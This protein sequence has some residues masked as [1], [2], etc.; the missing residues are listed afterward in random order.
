ML[1]AGEL[2]RSGRVARAMRNARVSPPRLASAPG[3]QAEL[4]EVFP[5][6]VEV[7]SALAEL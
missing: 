4:R 7:D 2:E 1:P 3:L 5:A 6:A